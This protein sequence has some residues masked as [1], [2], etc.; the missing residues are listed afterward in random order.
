MKSV[1]AGVFV[2]QIKYDKIWGISSST[3]SENTSCVYYNFAKCIT[4]FLFSCEWADQS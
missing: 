2:F 3:K 4:D 1:V